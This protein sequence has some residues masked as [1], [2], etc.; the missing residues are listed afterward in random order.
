MPRA[1]SCLLHV[2]CFVE[3]QYQTESKRDKNKRRIILE[4]LGFSGGRINAK[5]CPSWPRDRGR[6]L[7][8]GNA[9]HSPGTPVR[10]LTL[11]FSRKKSNFMR[12][13][14]AKDSPQSELRISGYKRN[15]EGAE[16]GNA[17][18]ERDREIDPISEGLSPLPSHES[19]GPEGKPFSHLGRRSRK[20]KKKGALSP[21]LPVAPEC[22]RGHYRATAIYTN[23]S[24]IFTNIFITFPHLST[25]VHLPQLAVPST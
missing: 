22:H 13:I 10:W 2:L 16:S 3:T 23:T 15:G 4:Y 12:K 25:A 1:S 17:E 21:S 6:A 14:W 7:P 24:V 9:W 18:T 11:F 19:Q 8:P 5:Q 20:K